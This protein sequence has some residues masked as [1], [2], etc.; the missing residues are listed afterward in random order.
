MNNFRWCETI[1]AM[2]SGSRVQISRFWMSLWSN[3]GWSSAL[4]DSQGAFKEDLLQLVPVLLMF[5]P[6][7]RILKVKIN[8]QGPKK[9]RSFFH[10][11]FIPNTSNYILFRTNCAI[12]WPLSYC[13]R[14]WIGH[15]YKTK[16]KEKTHHSQEVHQLNWLLTTNTKSQAIGGDILPNLMPISVK[17]TLRSSGSQ[18]KHKTLLGFDYRWKWSRILLSWKDFVQK[19]K[20]IHV[21]IFCSVWRVA[22]LLALFHLQEICQV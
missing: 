14:R 13:A 9:I 11:T 8:T 3:Q 12:H 16:K 19:E 15:D 6:M 2:S 5:V 1:T 20:C 21:Q 10:H 7:K 22:A 17:F 18:A 4:W